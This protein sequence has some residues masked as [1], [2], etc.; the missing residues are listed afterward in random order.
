MIFFS[1][2]TVEGEEP[3]GGVWSSLSPYIYTQ[4]ADTNREWA[5]KSPDCFPQETLQLVEV[6]L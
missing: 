1:W 2:L 5:I 3:A 6:S 4:E